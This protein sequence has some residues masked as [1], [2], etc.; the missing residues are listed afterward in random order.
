ME[1]IDGDGNLNND[2]TDRDTEFNV[3]LANYND[4][5]DDADGIPTREEILLDEEGNFVDFKDTDGDGTP[6]IRIGIL[7]YKHSKKKASKNWKPFLCLIL[8][9]FK[10]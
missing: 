3:F 5:D 2:N 9:L 8:Y 4:T 6:T 10:F 1:D 7:N